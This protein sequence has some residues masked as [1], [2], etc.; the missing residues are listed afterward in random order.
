MLLWFNITHDMFMQIGACPDYRIRC[1][2]MY[3]L[4]GTKW[5]RN[6]MGPLWCVDTVAQSDAIEHGVVRDPIKV[7]Y[8]RLYEPIDHIPGS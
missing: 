1:E 2:T 5:C 7:H 6:H 3:N 8:I 4:F